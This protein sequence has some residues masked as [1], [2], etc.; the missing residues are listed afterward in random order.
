MNGTH[1]RRHVDILMDDDSENLMHI[2]SAHKKFKRP[3]LIFPCDYLIASN[4][5]LFKRNQTVL[6][7]VLFNSSFAQK[8]H[9]AHTCI[10][11]HIISSWFVRTFAPAELEPS[12]NNAQIFGLVR[13]QNDSSPLSIASSK[14]NRRATASSLGSSLSRSSLSRMANVFWV[15]T[16]KQNRD[17]QKRYYV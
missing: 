9:N 17:K 16:L 12:S 3:L 2:S 7:S 8:Q 11:V 15:G 10:V 6:G 14:P 13:C 1:Q 4:Q 5:D